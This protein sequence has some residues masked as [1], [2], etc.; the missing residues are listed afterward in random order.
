MSL[1]FKTTLLVAASLAVL[2]SGLPGRPRDGALRRLRRQSEA[3]NAEQVNSL[4]SGLIYSRNILLSLSDYSN[5]SI[6]PIVNTIPK[7][8]S[9]FGDEIVSSTYKA[10]VSALDKVLRLYD[11]QA[12]LHG[13]HIGDQSVEVMALQVVVDGLVNQTCDWVRSAVIIIIIICIIIVLCWHDVLCM[14]K[15]YFVWTLPHRSSP[16]E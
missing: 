10:L 13:N 5:Y 1:Q 6:L 9:K 7:R 15:H 8:E 3:G 16:W 2:A 11:F 4:I 14:R 12:K